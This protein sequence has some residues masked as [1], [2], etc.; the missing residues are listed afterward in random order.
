MVGV[1]INTSGAVLVGFSIPWRAIDADIENPS[2][3]EGWER[4]LYGGGVG[5]SSK[6]KLVNLYLLRVKLEWCTKGH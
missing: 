6:H 2:S 5:V 3:S 1:P 4:R